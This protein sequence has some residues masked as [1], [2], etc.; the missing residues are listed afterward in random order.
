[1]KLIHFF[2]AFII[3][4]VMAAAPEGRVSERPRY[5]TNYTVPFAH[6]FRALKTLGTDHRTAIDRDVYHMARL[7]LDAF[8]L[9]LWDVEL[10]DAD[11][12]LQDNEH[13]EL[14]DYLVN[15]LQNR[16]ID[17][18]IT[19]QTNFGNGYPERNSDPYGA[20]SYDFPKCEVHD[21]PL[22]QTAQENYLS[23]L[24]NH[25]NR[26]NGRRIADDPGIIAIEINNEPCHSGTEDEIT[27]YINRMAKAL[28]NQGWKKDILYNVSHNL[29]RTPAFYRADIDGTT[30]QWY[31]T[32]LVKGSRRRGNFLPVLDDYRI[33]FDTIPGFNRMSRVIYEYDPADVLDSYLYPAAA[34]TFRKAGFDW[35]TQFAYDPVDM[36]AYNTEY[37]THF[38]N[39]AYTP[40]KAIGMMIAAEVTRR[41]PA[42]KDYGKYPRD[43]VFGPDNEFLTSARR[44]LAMLNDG[45][46]YFHTNRT[47]EKPRNPKS[48]RHV[49]GTGSSPLVETD[50][51][52][53][54]FLDKLPGN[55]WRMELM[56]DVYVTRDP[57]ATPSLNRRVAE[58]ISDSVGISV[59]L[60]DLDKS[61]RFRSLESD[62]ILRCEGGRLA[63]TPGVWFLGNDARLLAALDTGQTYAGGRLKLNEYVAPQPSHPAL[64]IIHLPAARRN[65]DGSITVT[66]TVV[67]DIR[68][69]SLVIYP[70]DV[71]FWNDSNRLYT[72]KRTGRNTYSAVIDSAAIGKKDCFRYNIV[73][74]AGGGP[75]VSTW[76]AGTSGTPLDW[77]FDKAANSYYSAVTAYGSGI[78]P[79]ISPGRDA[80]AAE[81]STVPEAWQGVRL[82][83]R[84]TAPESENRLLLHK[85]AHVPTEHLLLCKYVADAIERGI[86]SENSRIVLRLGTVEGIDS[87][88]VNIV[89][90]DGF[91][92]SAPVAVKS[93]ATVEV[94]VG[95][96]RLS[97][98][99]LTP[100]PYPSFL[101]RRFIPDTSAAPRLD[102]AETESIVI[103]APASPEEMNLEILGIYMTQ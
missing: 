63:L 21:N 19:A 69:D 59:A 1:M 26:Y 17:I 48:L 13:L 44:N 31:P 45:V 51:T 100:A 46:N 93:G 90:A 32:G 43:T 98:T 88:N 2:L 29:W 7:G 3:P 18:I 94:P 42:G 68:P 8:R 74:F 70:A 102:P 36:A 55:I 41:T 91:T 64:S 14:L 50:G 84:S 92:Y 86:P 54:Y 37:Q 81:L 4:A 83:H 71:N 24:V 27:A 33:P 34:R 80:D 25:V 38:L 87:L 49:A 97:P 40:G 103:D 35:I 16:G 53:A 15:A 61:F 73:A 77:D 20:F 66:A 82:T 89:S 23:Q 75:A 78:I 5:G 22:A 52:G 57:F 101:E 67:A 28:R 58:I 95:D 6:A 12:N 9:H 30:Y 10:A 47:D 65:T 76:P 99:W 85:D 96:L 60:P 39:L 56:P 11:G 62:S 72:M 79:L